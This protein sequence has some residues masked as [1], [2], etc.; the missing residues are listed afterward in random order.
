MT[1]T[2]PSKNRRS[3]KTSSAA[4]ENSSSISISTTTTTSSSNNKTVLSSSNSNRPLSSTKENDNISLEEQLD[5]AMIAVTTGHEQTLK[6]HHAWRSQIQ[7]ISILV[8]VVIM[9]QVT[10]PGSLCMSSI[11]NWNTKM[12]TLQHHHHYN[13]NVAAINII[14]TSQ[15]ISLMVKDSIMEGMSFFCSLCLLLWVS[16]ITPAMEFSNLF[17]RVAS[18]LLPL[19]VVTYSQDQTM[20]CLRH[21]AD[22]TPFLD[23]DKEDTEADMVY[24]SRA[25]PVVLVFY[26][27]VTL[28]I[29]AMKIQRTKGEENI[30]KIQKLQQDLLQSK[31]KK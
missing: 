9:T 26:L 27:V 13:M 21:F 24:P 17:F 6:L 14:S 25:F 20:G 18:T 8:L 1:T 10:A 28:S 11:R 15:T 29:G 7:R 31:K 4:F 5:R 30:Q 22:D 2:Q 23:N 3:K 12:E 16:T 19:I